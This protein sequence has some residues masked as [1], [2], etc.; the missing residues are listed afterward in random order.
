MYSRLPSGLSIAHDGWT[1]TA[2]LPMHVVGRGGQ[3]RHALVADQVYPLTVAAHRQLSEHP[4]GVADLVGGGDGRGP[5][6][7]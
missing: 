1:S 4:R 2:M 6:C 7:R 5:A 3:H